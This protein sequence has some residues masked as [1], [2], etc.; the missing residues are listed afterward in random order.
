M[1]I[2]I[3][4]VKREDAKAIADIYNHYI[5]NTTITFEEEEITGSD[6]AERIKNV[7]S[8]HLPW[9]VAEIEGEI[10]GY[11]YATKWK[12]RSAYRYTVESVIYLA[13]DKVGHGVG[14]MLYKELISILK[15]ANI[16]AI[17]G[18]I[19]LPNPSSVSLH[20]KL[21]FEQVAYFKEVGIKFGKWIDVG[22]W[23]LLL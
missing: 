15:Q 19:A 22:K 6:I 10:L 5:K 16:H 17:I 1:N 14:S 12:L 18:T 23:Q 4:N 9:M 3:R 2:M 8:D 11:T 20:E 13:P 7:I 21:G